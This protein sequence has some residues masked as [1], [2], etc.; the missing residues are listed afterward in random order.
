M[1]CRIWVR[2]CGLSGCRRAGSR[3]AVNPGFQDS[4]VSL[5]LKVHTDMATP[6]E[7]M[8]VHSDFPR[9]V[10]GITVEGMPQATNLDHSEDFDALLKVRTQELQ[11]CM[12]HELHCICRYGTGS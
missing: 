2:G 3:R 12:C 11:I 1:V 8:S 5:D 10:L 6:W 7:K 9:M 4:P